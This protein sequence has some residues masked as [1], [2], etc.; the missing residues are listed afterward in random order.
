MLKPWSGIEL[1]APHFIRCRIPRDN[2]LRSGTACGGP[3]LDNVPECGF[4]FTVGRKGSLNKESSL[5]DQLLHFDRSRAFFMGSSRGPELQC[6]H[7]SFS[8]VCKPVEYSDRA[9]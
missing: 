1:S 2:R 3:D 4:G 5:F 8:H 6:A 9:L 7:A